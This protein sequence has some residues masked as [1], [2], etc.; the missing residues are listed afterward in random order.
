VFR[1]RIA[2]GFVCLWPGRTGKS[3]VSER[4]SLW[5]GRYVKIPWTI[6]DE[7]WAQDNRKLAAYVRGLLAED[8][9]R[10]KKRRYYIPA[11]I[12]QGILA[13]FGYRCAYC[14]IS[15]VPLERE[16]RIARSRGG[17]DHESNI[18]P[19]CRPCNASKGTDDPENWP[20]VVPI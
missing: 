2:P 7:D 10:R 1:L 13:A 14:G 6:L 18:V 4:D 5:S 15:D 12:W 16:H 11:T 9:E 17:S 20:I 8:M 3:R 19:S